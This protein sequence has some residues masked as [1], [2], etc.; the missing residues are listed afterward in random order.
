MLET[1]KEEELSTQTDILIL[2][3]TQARIGGL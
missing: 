2:M 3:A 1:M